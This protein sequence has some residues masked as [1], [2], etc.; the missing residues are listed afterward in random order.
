MF[1]HI[2]TAAVRREDDLNEVCSNSNYIAHYTAS[3]TDFSSLVIVVLWKDNLP[4]PS[5][6]HDGLPLLYVHHHSRPAEDFKD[7]K[8]FQQQ[9]KD[10]PA[11]QHQ[12]TGEEYTF[13]QL[14]NA[15][16]MNNVIGKHFERLFA[17]HSNLMA[18]RP[19]DQLNDGAHFIEFVVLCK[20]FIPS[21]DKSP[22]PRDLDGIPTR[23]SSGWIELCGRSE[24]LYHRPLRPGAGFAVGVDANLDLSASEEDYH[25]PVIGTIGGFYITEDGQTYGVTCG[26]CL[27]VIANSNNLHPAGSPI[28]QPCA[29]GIIVNAA[30]TDPGL[31]DAYDTLKESKGHLGAM[32]WMITQ[33]RDND[34][35]FSTDLPLDAQCG[36]VLG[37]VLGP[38][39]TVGDTHVDVG[40]VTLSIPTQQKCLSSRK[41]PELQSPD[42]YFKEGEDPM[43]KV[44]QRK[45]FPQTCF[46][47]YGRGAR[48]IDTMRATVNPLQT[49]MYFRTLELSVDLVFRCIHAETNMNWQP[50][51]SGTWCWT[52]DKKLVGM[53]IGY[54]HIEGKHFCC[55]L[56]MT[57]V[58]ESIQ[59][60]INR[61]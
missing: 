43:Q 41:F 37:G 46:Y 26:H 8:E 28:F 45:N 54:A 31:L 38:L 22:L 5:I 39:D 34:N 59:H 49:D 47:V 3:H 61:R 35:S 44:L 1:A 14:Q 58:L 23:V 52:E 25:P 18:I 53:G 56:P 33:L 11:L 55:M 60:L 42:L 19:S 6:V 32:K 7:W 27:R 50:G 36:C 21:I 13:D 16:M 4:G 20:N 57:N 12:K 9:K 15:T 2:Q 48:S 10:D 24:Q 29:M 40:L 30:S 51:D 17:S